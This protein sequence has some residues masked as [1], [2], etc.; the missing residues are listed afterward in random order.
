MT[1]H[2]QGLGPEPELAPMV[3]RQG[4]IEQ[5]VHARA[6]KGGQQHCLPAGPGVNAKG[7]IRVVG[8]EMMGV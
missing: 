8:A 3:D 1:Q 2:A 6:H 4:P 5:C 7:F